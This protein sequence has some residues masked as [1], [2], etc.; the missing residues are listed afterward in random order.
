MARTVTQA[1]RMEGER[2]QAA[3][4]SLPVVDRLYRLQPADL[5]GV[6]AR[7]RPATVR[8]VSAQGIERPAP[9]IH[10]QGMAKPLVLDAANVSAMANLAGS[11]LQRDWLGLEVVLAVVVEGDTPRIRLLAPG[12]PALAGLHRKSVQAERTKALHL[13]TRQALRAAVLFLGLIAA[14]YTAIYLIDNWA[15]LLAALLSV[16]DALRNNS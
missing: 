10:F 14:S 16:V 2:S 5:G 3:D 15:A 1:E 4:R 8:F 13:Y 6:H 9:V 12:D 7:P 11:P